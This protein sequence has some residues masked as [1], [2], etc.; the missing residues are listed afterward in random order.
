MSASRVTSKGTDMNGYSISQGPCARF[1]DLCEFAS[2]LAALALRSLDDRRGRGGSL[3]THPG[4]SSS[5]SKP[6]FATA[7]TTAFW[8]F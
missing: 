2:T 7:S 6:T 8:H 1:S 4:R 3:V 5:N